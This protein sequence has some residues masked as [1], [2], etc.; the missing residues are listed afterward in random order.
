MTRLQD[1]PGYRMRVGDWRVIYEIKNDKL[2][3]VVIKVASRGDI[4]R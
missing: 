3:I 1:R 4:Y 2:V